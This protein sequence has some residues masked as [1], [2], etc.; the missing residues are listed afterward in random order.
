[1]E[2]FNSNPGQENAPGQNKVFT[3]YVN[4]KEKDCT[5]KEISYEQIVV[6]AGYPPPNDPNL[7]YTITY[8]K[9]DS[10]KPEG[11]MVKGDIVNVK[12]GMKFN[13]TQTNRS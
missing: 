4:S 5:E 10:A 9:R 8:K 3:I 12:N 6:L 2:K 13:V 7:F 1:M 11:T